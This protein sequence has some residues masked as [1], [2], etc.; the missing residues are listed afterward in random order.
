MTINSWIAMNFRRGQRRM[1]ARFALLASIAISVGVADVQ[2]QD[3][4]GDSEQRLNDFPRMLRE[5]F[6]PRNESRRD[7]R[8]MLKLVQPVAEK[9]SESVITVSVD[10]QSVAL[11]T[12]IREDGL[13][14]TKGSELGSGRIKVRLADRRMYDARVIA[15]RKSDDLAVLKFDA[16]GLKPIQFDQREPP[17]GS[18]LVSPGT[19][20]DT[21]GLGVVGNEARSIDERGVLGVR[22]N[23]VDKGVQVVAILPGSNAGSVGIQRGDVLLKVNDKEIN[24]GESLRT[25]IETMFPGDRA[26]LLV[27]RD[28]RTFDVEVQVRDETVIH[29]T[30]NDARVHGN[31][32]GRLAG[33]SKVLQH[34]TVLEP[35]QCGGPVLDLSGSVVGINI[36]R[37]GRVCSYA[38]PSQVILPALQSM[39][40]SP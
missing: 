30:E 16:K 33:F 28:D 34:D 14:I 13:A 31:R 7:S 17:V 3:I 20:V 26:K 21:S 39:L 18:F 4:F 36:A 15:A 23:P 22:F 32:S 2:A 40:P 10:G 5:S 27:Q 29:E 38:L 9:V 1:L 25:E 12:I 6:G 35:D 11:G 24:S 8:D 37:A 19:S